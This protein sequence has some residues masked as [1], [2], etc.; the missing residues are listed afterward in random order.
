MLLNRSRL[1][2]LVGYFGPVETAEM[3]GR[4]IDTLA[5]RMS[6]L[7]GTADASLASRLGHEI[8]GMA[9]MY[10]L[11]T[12]AAAALAIER[13]ASGESLPEMVR[14][15]DRLMAEAVRELGAFA[16]GLAASG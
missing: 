2:A 12:V 9:G 3:I 1:E 7:R 8:K 4:V 13:G 14:E 11:D 15:L 10:G 5:V 6:D 16:A